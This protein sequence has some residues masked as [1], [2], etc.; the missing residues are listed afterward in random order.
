MVCPDMLVT[1]SPGLVAVPLGIFSTAGTT[2][3][4]YAIPLTPEQ[5]VE[6]F[7]NDFKNLNFRNIITYTTGPEVQVFEIVKKPELP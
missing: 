3:V 6:V 2:T 1:M 7:F 5:T 4:S